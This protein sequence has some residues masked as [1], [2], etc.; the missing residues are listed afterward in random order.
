M[1]EKVRRDSA[2]SN[3]LHHNRQQALPGNQKDNRPVSRQAD[4]LPA[5]DALQMAAGLRSIQ[6][7]RL[8]S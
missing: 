8:K 2:F 6:T 4:R 1:A 7:A 3:R 5:L